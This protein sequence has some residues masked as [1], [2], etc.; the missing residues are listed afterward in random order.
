MKE[1]GEKLAH[2]HRVL[3]EIAG[4]K[5]QI[6]RFEKPVQGQGAQNLI[7]EADK[8]DKSL[9]GVQKALYQ[10]KN[11]SN[12]DPLNYPIKLTTG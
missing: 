11:R 10:T 9:T 6:N 5:K 7:E 3:A 2:T 8:L 4:V 1:T 12:Q